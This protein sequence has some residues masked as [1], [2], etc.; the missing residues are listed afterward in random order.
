M[1]KVAYLENNCHFDIIFSHPESDHQV[2][3]MPVWVICKEGNISYGIALSDIA[4]LSLVNIRLN[5]YYVLVEC[6]IFS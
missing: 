3:Q 2:N 5:C 1:P 4:V 6:F